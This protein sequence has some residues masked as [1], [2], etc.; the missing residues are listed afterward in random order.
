MDLLIKI[1]VFLPYIILQVKLRN[2][3]FWWKVPGMTSESHPSLFLFCLRA[4]VPYSFCLRTPL[5]IM[6]NISFAKKVHQRNITVKTPIRS[7]IFCPSLL[8][9]QPLIV[10]WC[11]PETWPVTSISFCQASPQQPQQQRL[12]WGRAAE[13]G[14]LLGE[15]VWREPEQVRQRGRQ[16]PA[17]PEIPL[18]WGFGQRPAG[19]DAQALRLR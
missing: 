13:E 15:R 1:N 11:R 2:A 14:C 9:G 16:P 19:Q 17:V 8:K 7:R 4:N 12:G 6:N 3:S 10:R 18:R 5:F